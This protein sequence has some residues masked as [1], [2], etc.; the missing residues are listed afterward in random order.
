LR[1]TTDAARGIIE[2]TRGE[3]TAALR[4][5]ELRAALEQAL[6]AVN[7]VSGQSSGHAEENQ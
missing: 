6:T 3:L 4:Q 5:D 7:Q 2:K 1:R